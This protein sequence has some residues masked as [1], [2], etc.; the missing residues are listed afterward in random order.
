MKR[1][2][3]RNL[4]KRLFACAVLAM[5]HFVPQVTIGELPAYRQLTPMVALHATSISDAARLIND[6]LA[7]AGMEIKSGDSMKILAD[8]CFLPSF[9][10]IDLRRPARYFLLSMDPPSAM[11]EQAIILPIQPGGAPAILRSLRERYASIEGGSI[12]ICS[13]PTDGK[14]VEPLYVAI[15]EGNAMLSPNVDAIRWMAYN[16]QSK[17]VP[18][19]PD[20]RR[21]PLSASA[22][23]R[24]LGI[25]LELI[26]SL[27]E[28][29]SSDEA[30]DMDI[31]RHIRETGVFISAFQRLEVAIDASI[32][33]WD[34]SFRLVGAPGSQIAEAIAALKPPDDTWMGLFPTFACNRS[35]SCLP[36]FISALP[37]SNRKWLADLADNTRIVGH[38]LFPSAFDL[39][40]KIR[41]YLTGTALST[42]VTDKPGDKFGSVTVLAVKSPEGALKVLRGYFSPKGAASANRRIE[43]V[44][45]A[46]KKATISYNAVAYRGMQQKTGIER[47]GEAVSF[48]LNLNHVQLALSGNRLFVARGASGLIEPWL[49]EK[50][51]AFWD[52]KVSSLT[53]VFPNQP[54]ETVLGG[55][56]ID[57]VTLARKIVTAI[58]D[59]SPHLKKMPHAGSGFAWRMARKG[60]EA[61][62]DI[63]LYSN[64]IIACN[65]LREV[66]S[67][68]MQQLL[69][70]FVLRHFQQSAN[71]EAERERLRER[72][73]TLRDK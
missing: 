32:S 4:Y 64:E 5:V 59:L 68:T 66:N 52:E 22:D 50:K 20:F 29:D 54:G 67:E 73:N 44:V 45:P 12:K 28:E 71:N 51:S 2:R 35:A 69:S 9:A 23:T 70:Q 43:N 39:D 7:G 55:G 11:P 27:N 41:P 40:E 56:S 13:D 46:D 21:S 62:F 38:A 33:Q 58:P 3:V 16:L 36:G 6:G 65:M 24:L 1:G 63:R 37:A 42:F 25:L 19:P 10:G 26:A 14:S 48:V 53:A 8:A 15:A 47:T 72:L 61:R 34:V 18:D 31:F 57:P 30:S 60:G 49:D 17:T